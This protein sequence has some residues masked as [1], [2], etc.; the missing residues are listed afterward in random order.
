MVK[1]IFK[2]IGIVLLVLILLLILGIGVIFII[3]KIEDGKAWDKLIQGGYVNT[4]NVEDRKM[5]VCLRGNKDAEYTVVS[6]QGLNNM[7]NVVEMEAVTEP[8]NDKY[9]FAFVDRAG[10]GLSEDT[11]QEQTVEQI[12]S[13]YRTALQNAGIKAPYILMAHSLEGVYAS[14]W[15]QKFP[16]EIKAVIYLDHTQ[17]GS[18]DEIRDE[19]DDRHADIVMYASVVASKLGL[20]RIIFNSKEYTVNLQTEKQKEYAELIWRLCPMSWTVCSEGFN[21]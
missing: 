9:R 2:I 17:I 14:Y 16:D 6:L 15:Q 19:I 21:S 5:N 11:H 7:A 3:D 4:V 8:L 13:D 20:D 10:Y 12:T 18:I 1:K